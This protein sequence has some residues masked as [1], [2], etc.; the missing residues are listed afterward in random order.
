MTNLAV[1]QSY[2]LF[3]NVFG[4]DSLHPTITYHWTKDNGTQTQ[5]G[6]DST[7]FFSLF[8]LSDA[9]YFA[10]E[11]NVSSAYLD[12]VITASNM[13]LLTVQSESVKICQPL[14]K[15]LLCSAYSASSS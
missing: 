9:G 3:C 1:G 7:L 10:C 14:H 4:A 5:V 8:R 2:N 11:V 13:T 12:N 15:S 6:T